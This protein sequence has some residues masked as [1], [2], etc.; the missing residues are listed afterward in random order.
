MITVVTDVDVDCHVLFLADRAYEPVCVDL[1]V[2]VS[3]LIFIE[4]LFFRWM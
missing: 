4:L 1:H 2:G 3:V